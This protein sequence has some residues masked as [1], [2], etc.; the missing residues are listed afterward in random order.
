MVFNQR[1]LSSLIITKILFGIKITK[2]NFVEK[3]KANSE[4][5]VFAKGREKE[6]LKKQ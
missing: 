5:F 6:K 1:N 3:Q 2:E 4:F